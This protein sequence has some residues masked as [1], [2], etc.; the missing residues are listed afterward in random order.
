MG[1]SLPEFEQI[2]EL[3][4]E[5]AV[6]GADSVSAG[7]V[8]I[9]RLGSDRF[10]GN[11]PVFETVT[12]KSQADQHA[13]LATVEVGFSAVGK[14]LPKDQGFLRA[15]AVVLALLSKVAIE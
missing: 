4:F 3:V 6:T 8:I 10:F 11:R 15:I 9:P 2:F 5:G 7:Q 14:A 1:L 13:H 12:A